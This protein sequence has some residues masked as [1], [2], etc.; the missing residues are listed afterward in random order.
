MSVNITVNGKFKTHHRLLDDPAKVKKDEEQ[1]R[2]KLRLLQ[3]R[4]ESKKLAKKIRDEVNEEKKR[5]LQKLQETKEKELECW[6]QHAL[7]RAGEEYRSAIFQMGTAHKAAR[8]ENVKRAEKQQQQ[9]TTYKEFKKQAAKRRAN[10]RK[11]QTPCPCLNK[12]FK[13]ICVQTDIP[14]YPE[15]RTAESQKRK[16]NC[17]FSSSDSEHEEEDDKEQ[18]TLPQSTS[19]SFSSTTSDS[20]ISALQVNNRATQTSLCEPPSNKCLIKT[21]A[22]YVDVEVGS[23]DSFSISAPIEINDKHPAYNRKFTNI[24]M[25]SPRKGRKQCENLNKNPS[26][27][28]STTTTTTQ[29]SDVTVLPSEEPIQKSSPKKKI[30]E[31]HATQ[32]EKRFTIVSDLV[33]KQ[34][35]QD[36]SSKTTKDTKSTPPVCPPGSRATTTTTTPPLSPRKLIRPA[37][38]QCR[39][40]RKTS[41][42]SKSSKTITDNSQPTATL[43]TTKTHTVAPSTTSSSGRVQFFN[44][45]TKLCKERDQA[46]ANVSVQ[47][48]NREIV[49]PTAMEQAALENQRERERQ[50]ETLKKNQ[51]MEERSQ[52][53]L[54]REQIRRDCNE[55]TEKLDALT[56]EYP[57]QGLTNENQLHI[58][59]DKKLRMEGKMNSAVEK[60]LNRP[61]IITCSEINKENKME[62]IPTVA[63]QHQSVP[64]NEINVGAIHQKS[65]PV[66]DV[67]S[68]SCCS[69]LL[70]YVDD[71]S[72][73]VKQDLLNSN[74]DGNQNDS[75]QERLKTLLKRLDELRSSLLEELKNES[76]SKT[77]KQSKLSSDGENLKHVVDSISEMRKER[78]QILNNDRAKICCHKKREK[79]LKAKE[80]IL[81]EKV[82]EFFE[83]QKQQK[84]EKDLNR[85]KNKENETNSSPTTKSTQK[86]VISNDKE[87]VIRTAGEKPVEIVITLRDENKKLQVLSKHKR[88]MTN[89]KTPSKVST[90]IRSPQPKIA[91]AKRHTPKKKSQ[92]TSARREEILNRQSSYDSNSTSYMSLNSQLNTQINQLAERI[93]KEKQ[94][95]ESSPKVTST[96]ELNKPESKDPVDSS[97]NVP[98]VRRPARLNPL[99]AQYVQRLLG[100]SRNAVSK[101]GVSS[102]DIETPG[103]SIINTPSNVSQAD[104]M[105]SDESLIQIHNFMEENKS[106]IKELE[107]S[108]RSQNNDALETSIKMFDDIWRKCLS[109]CYKQE[110]SKAKDSTQKAK[111][112]KVSTDA[113]T[114]D[115]KSTKDMQKQNKTK[116]IKSNSQQRVK[117]SV[118]DD[119]PKDVAKSHTSSSSTDDKD[120]SKSPPKSPKERIVERVDKA[121]ETRNSGELVPDNSQIARYAKLTENCTNRIAELTELINKVR[122]EKQRLLEVTLSSVS[123]NG[124]QSTEYLDL[125]EGKADTRNDQEDRTKV[126]STSS[127]ETTQ[128]KQSYS[129]DTLNETPKLTSDYKNKQTT[130]SRDS[131]IAESRPITSLENRID[132]EPTSQTSSESTVTQVAKKLKPPPTLLRFSPQLPEEEV[133]HELSTIFEVDTPATSRINMAAGQTV[134]ERESSSDKGEP[135]QP[136]KF[137]T[138]EEYLK[139]LD[140]NATQLDPEQSTQLQQEFNSFLECLQKC[141]SN[142]APKYTEFPSASK[143]LEKSPDV[144]E[145][146]ETMEEMLAQLCVGNVL[147]RNFPAVREYIK[148]NASKASSDEQQLLD[149]ES[150]ENISSPANSE[151]ET[152]SLDIEEE[153][154]RR[155]ILKSSFRYLKQKHK[156]FSSTANKDDEFYKEMLAAESG[157]E[158]LS[159][160]GN[161]TEKL[162]I[163]MKKITHKLQATKNKQQKEQQA[164]LLSSSTNTANTSTLANSAMEAVSLDESSKDKGKALNL[165]DFLTR[166]LL[167]RVNIS[168]SSS[169]SDESLRSHFFLS[170][171][172]SLTPRTPGVASKSGAPTIERQKTS[173]PVPTPR[174]N[175]SSR[176]N[177]SSPSHLFSGESHISSVRFVISDSGND[178][179]SSE[180]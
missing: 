65:L 5:E 2:R 75:K 132:Q 78:E 9:Q 148:G 130:A 31:K 17:S 114:N 173:T 134:N 74:T 24:I 116:T 163:D 115:K 153:L 36:R 38:P 30:D 180:S 175:N 80:A 21:P 84:F 8:R 143:Y 58:F 28:Q 48:Q 42:L 41:A 135:Q 18:N 90:L 32:K 179:H 161:T 156:I 103:S 174:S 97:N 98:N 109:E 93:T 138:F 45:K 105:L 170:I 89:R 72:K 59:A 107:K 178:D 100:M 92:P 52:K 39:S 71:Q 29:S 142:D 169:S 113:T 51:Q 104:T 106:F 129:T 165:R 56:R 35:Q 121:I 146:S 122:E 79:E 63:V 20:T 127:E 66:D 40:P 152:V 4:E 118:A 95:P 47:R 120:I 86:Q 81:E 26:I 157:L 171:L 126:S 102:S 160:S 91:A 159:S 145:L 128:N 136:I 61:A 147:P 62:T 37:V 1:E 68:D 141:A 7:D 137:P 139:V 101:L 119:V 99:I 87:K 77:K 76:E 22:V 88:R 34:Q 144:D 82:R 140:L 151:N 94:N 55:L 64:I 54:E 53:A 50:L 6:R 125:P 162:E 11:A 67:S 16:R 150:L 23:Q 57:N 43:S 155:K 13:C 19:S 96:Q 149:T 14:E 158:K 164:Q 124:R 108:I 46:A 25:V 15:Q 131:G 49:Q 167:K 176:A 69:I 172:G 177:K 12:E 168:G 166:E 73:L 10:Q 27:E 33:K 111:K 117:R 44:Y 83:L 110:A 85:N 154:K 3:V 112:S 123:E 70:G 133:A 60:L